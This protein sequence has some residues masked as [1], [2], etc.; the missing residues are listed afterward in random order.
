MQNCLAM[1]TCQ[2]IRVTVFT[3]DVNG[4]EHVEG[5]VGR[6]KCD[7]RNINQIDKVIEVDEH[8]TGRPWRRN[9]EKVSSKRRRVRVPH[10]D[11]LLLEK[12]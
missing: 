6:L 4:K 8:D 1:V 2:K 5:V 11:V 12:E 10:E 3:Q 7:L 9:L